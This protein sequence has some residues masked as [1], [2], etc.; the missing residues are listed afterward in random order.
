MDGSHV[1]NLLFPPPPFSATAGDIED[2]LDGNLCRCTGIYIRVHFF[3]YMEFNLYTFIICRISSDPGCGQ[4]FRLRCFRYILCTT[5]QKDSVG[6]AHHS[7]FPVLLLIPRVSPFVLIALLQRVAG[8]EDNAAKANAVGNQYLLK[9]S[10][11]VN[12]IVVRSGRVGD[13]Y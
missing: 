1:V 11:P 10:H 8:R 5:Y 9:I 7:V 13:H 4:V 6:P 12:C 3:W 2:S